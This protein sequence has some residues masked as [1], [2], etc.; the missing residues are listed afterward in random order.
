MKATEQHFPRQVS[1]ACFLISP[2]NILGL[3]DLFKLYCTHTNDPVLIIQYL[4]VY[5][6]LLHS[7]EK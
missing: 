2:L 7:K 6:N 4:T 5:L 3:K 1:I